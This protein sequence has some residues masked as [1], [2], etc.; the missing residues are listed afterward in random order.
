MTCPLLCGISYDFP[1]IRV[2]GL[3]YQTDE[4]SLREAFDKYGQVVEGKIIRTFLICKPVN[5][6]E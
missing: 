1:L 2:A 6:V 4:N 5:S 3:S